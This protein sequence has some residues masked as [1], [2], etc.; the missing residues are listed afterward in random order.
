MGRH[1]DSFQAS[2]SSSVSR[3]GSLGQ[4][5]AIASSAHSAHGVPGGTSGGA[6]VVVV[7]SG[8]N[9]VVVVVVVVVGV[10]VVVGLGSVGFTG[11]A[12]WAA[13][14]HAVRAAAHST[15]ANLMRQPC[16]ACRC[17]CHSCCGPLFEMTGDANGRNGATD[18]GSGSRLEMSRHMPGSVRAAA[19]PFLR[20]VHLT[21]WRRSCQATPPL[22]VLTPIR[23]PRCGTRGA[24]CLLVAFVAGVRSEG[25]AGACCGAAWFAC[26]SAVTCTPGALIFGATHSVSLISTITSLNIGWLDLILLRAISA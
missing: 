20:W 3:C 22:P 15:A 26:V 19:F 17:S 23:G 5:P 7:V 14:L 25:A 12:L 1:R 24:G 2:L 21:I 6:V 18:A 10:I 4:P 13:L 8:G 9:V 16:V 11:W